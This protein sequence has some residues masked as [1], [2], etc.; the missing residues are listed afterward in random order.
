MMLPRRS[1]RS[2]RSLAR[3]KMA[4]T[5]E[6]T[7]ISKPSS[8]GKPLATPPSEELML[9]RAR[10]FMSMTRRQVTRRGSKPPPV[11]KQKGVGLGGAGRIWGEGV[12][13]RWPGEGV[14]VAGEWKV[15]GL[16]G[17]D[18]GIA[19]AGSTTLDAEAGAEAGLAQADHR[20]LADPV[21]P[22]AEAHRRRCLALARRRRGDGG[23]QD[24]LAV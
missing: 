24:Q 21:E 11:P 22:V 18:L 13:G 3:Q 6:A 14:E 1:F 4:M 16:H 7:V 12:R 5:S 10:S 20:L 17:H 15:D 8:R 2:L 19:A 9:R 23:D